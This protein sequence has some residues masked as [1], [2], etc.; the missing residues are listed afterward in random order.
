[1]LDFK[2]QIYLLFKSAAVTLSAYVQPKIR[3]EKTYPVVWYIKKY[4]S[5][6]L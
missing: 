6:I 3:R 5:D 4:V 2:K 1:M